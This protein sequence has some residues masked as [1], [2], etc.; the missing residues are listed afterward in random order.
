MSRTYAEWKLRIG[1]P[2]ELFWELQ[3]FLEK[4]GFGMGEPSE[5]LTLEPTPIEGPATFNKDVEG[6]RFYSVCIRWMFILGI[7]L[8][9]T[10]ILIPIGIWLIRKS[11]YDVIQE[12][13]IHVEGETFRASALSQEPHKHQSEVIDTVSNARVSLVGKVYRK[14]GDNESKPGESEYQVFEKKL[15][16]IEDK[17]NTLIPSIKLPDVTGT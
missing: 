14:K 9:F 12:V 6:Q 11:V 3:Q 8:C 5:A 7:I 13:R 1:S 15:G 10:I 17:L 16:K 4:E 2:R